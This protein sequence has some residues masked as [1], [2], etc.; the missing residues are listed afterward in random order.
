MA[1]GESLENLAFEIFAPIEKKY[2]S[3]TPGSEFSLVERLLKYRS[4]EK[5]IAEKFEQAGRIKS[6]YGCMFSLPGFTFSTKASRIVTPPWVKIS[7]C[8]P[9]WDESA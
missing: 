6:I 1:R 4:L 3:K 8:A 5:N 7:S 9:S 2:G